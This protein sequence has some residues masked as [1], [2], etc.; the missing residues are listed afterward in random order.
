MGLKAGPY[1]IALTPTQ[2]LQ[3][4]ALVTF[5]A[6]NPES[7][8]LPSFSFFC[9][10][11]TAIV[12]RTEGW[13]GIPGPLTLGA[14]LTIGGNLEYVESS[15]EIT[16]W[17]HP[18][19][20]AVEL[21]CT[22]PCRLFC[23]HTVFTRYHDDGRTWAREPVETIDLRDYH[24]GHF[25]WLIWPEEEPVKGYFRIGSQQFPFET[26]DS[27][28]VRPLTR[29]LLIAGP[30]ASVDSDSPVTARLRCAG[31]PHF[32]QRVE[33]R[34]HPSDPN[35]KFVCIV[36]S[37][38]VTGYCEGEQWVEY[39]NVTIEAEPARTLKI[40]TTATDQLGRSI[41]YTVPMTPADGPEVYG[42]DLTVA[43]DWPDGQPL[44][45]TAPGTMTR[46]ASSY[47]LIMGGRIH[48]VA[49]VPVYD[50]VNEIENPGVG[51]I[52]PKASLEERNLNPDIY[53]CP[54]HIQ[55]LEFASCRVFTRG[56][57]SILQGWSGVGGTT[58]TYASG[59]MQVS[60][61]TCTISR[62]LSLQDSIR[63]GRFLRIVF[64]S[65]YTGTVTAQYAGKS[66]SVQ[67][68]ESDGKRYCVIDTCCPHGSKGLALDYTRYQREYSGGQQSASQGDWAWGLEP[69]ANLQ[70]TF[71]S[72]VEIEFLGWVQSQEN[73]VAL[74]NRVATVEE[75]FRVEDEDIFEVYAQRAVAVIANGKVAVDEPAGTIKRALK[76]EARAVT[77]SSMWQDAIDNRKLG[78][79]L[80]YLEPISE[81]RV[82]RSYGGRTFYEK[83]CTNAL[84]AYMTLPGIYGVSEDRIIIPAAL[85]FDRVY[86]DTGVSLDLRCNLVFGGSAIGIAA[87]ETEGVPGVN[88]SAVYQS[89]VDTVQ[90]GS[91]GTYR[92]P[93]ISGFYRHTRKFKYRFESQQVTEQEARQELFHRVSHGVE[94]EPQESQILASSDYGTTEMVLLTPAKQTRFL[95]AR[96]GLSA[97]RGVQ[98][99]GESASIETGDTKDGVLHLA[100]ESSGS[101]YYIKSQNRG[102]TW[103]NP[104]QIA[105]GT[106]PVLRLNRHLGVLALGYIRGGT[107]YMRQSDASGFGSE[108]AVQTQAQPVAFTYE[109]MPDGS[110]SLVY[111][112]GSGN[113]R[114]VKSSDNGHT[115]TE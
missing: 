29:M 102:E 12:Y 25:Y 95:D 72:N 65:Y 99:Q 67:T 7:G 30:L 64:Y 2:K 41:P 100:Y 69:G 77:L 82:T 96:Y 35:K 89:T 45:P 57:Y 58:V 52:L 15:V 88:V 59:R 105:T 34:A 60:G 3:V 40:T 113:L 85:T 17:P 19:G 97:S 26:Q 4:Q 86:L 23:S 13:Y 47:L 111:Q 73:P 55:E 22:L 78:D 62:S 61:G 68:Q 6:F 80:I 104:M 5:H 32:R 49:L 76:D 54:L 87:S 107:I 81:N 8:G 110:I 83:Y 28:L 14:Y 38:Q 66:W 27:S 94:V 63:Q 37:D 91:G 90:T 108:R 84:P 109:F 36:D 48:G 93:S 103:G 33:E 71:E 1:H 39:I 106:K 79:G 43:R 24:N 112:D 98:F 42:H 10:P 31:N 18:P 46:R 16:Q 51:F 21:A 53:R 92:L 9:G 74:V 70:L 11:I 56:Q 114:Y 75:P 101:V 20:I 115:W 50:S 44:Y